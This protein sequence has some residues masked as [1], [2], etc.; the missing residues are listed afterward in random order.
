MAHKAGLFAVEPLAINIRLPTDVDE[1]AALA[2]VVKVSVEGI[3]GAR[4]IH[5]EG[6]LHV[7]VPKQCDAHMLHK[8][9]MNEVHSFFVANMDA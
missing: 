1:A 9:V 3:H 4:F 5:D 8:F 2:A 7:V 6:M